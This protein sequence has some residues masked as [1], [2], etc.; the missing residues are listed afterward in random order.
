[1]GVD[2]R[3]ADRQPHTHA[4]GFRREEGFEQAVHHFRREARTGSS[5]VISTVPGLPL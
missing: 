4:A 3:A 2:D 5:T 1:M